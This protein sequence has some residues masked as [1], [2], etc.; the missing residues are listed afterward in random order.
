MMKSAWI[1]ASILAIANL[2]AIAGFIGWL[3]ATHRLSRERVDAVK[4][5]FVKSV[6]DEEHEKAETQAQ[7]QSA[8]GVQDAAPRASASPAGAAEIIAVRRVSERV[9][10]QSLLRR[11]SELKALRES[12]QR[13]DERLR[14]SWDDLQK[15]E[16]AF[17]AERKKIIDIEGGEQ[18]KKALATVEALKPK[19]AQSMLSALIKQGKTDEVVAYLNAMEERSRG[20]VMAEFNKA[21][22]KLAA[23]LLER[24]RT[25]GVLAA[26]TEEGRK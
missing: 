24:L 20:K 4:H 15:R 18:F 25:R 8:I 17:R 11:D 14:K 22:P 23:D 16:T 12:L 6:T 7:A 19:D 3:G 1:T 10:L 13:D 9:E 21:D 2:L 5:I 26:G